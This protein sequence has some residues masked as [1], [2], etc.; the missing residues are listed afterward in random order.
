MSGEEPSKAVDGTVEN[1]SKW[2]SNASGDKWLRLD[3]G[4]NYSINRWVVKH[5]GAGGESATWNTS[6]FKLQKSSDGSAFTDVDS[7]IGN[8]AN[9]TDRTVTA[10]TNR[11]VRL[12]I[13]K[14][15]STTDGAARIYE[16][17]LYGNP[18]STPTPGPTATPTPTPTSGP[19]ATPTPSPI[20]G[21]D[22]IIDNFESGITSWSTYQGTTASVSI[23]SVAGNPGSAMA[24]TYTGGD[25]WGVVKSIQRDISAY[26]NLS[27]DVKATNSNPVR[28]VISEFA[29]DGTSDGEQ[30]QVTLTAGTSFSTSVFS[31]SSGF[32]KRS[33]WQ[34]SGQD[35]NGV[36]NRNNIKKIEFMHS[37]SSSGSMTVDNIKLTGGTAT[38]TPTP[39]ATA[40]PTPA[41]T[42]TP[43]PTP[44]NTATPTPTDPRAVIWR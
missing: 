28:L 40:T 25:Y 15:T 29:T 19:T 43:T 38:P 33:D 18:G 6:D 14:P 21:G 16:L 27:I 32:T 41:S 13:T 39:T 24:I 2:C 22:Y 17:E 12:Y 8:T 4:Q 5:A 26:V 3:L 10:F 23:T 42:A 35:N 9:I 36:F 31:L 11:Y 37:N 7:V 34:P 30:W 44:A 1:N 20:P